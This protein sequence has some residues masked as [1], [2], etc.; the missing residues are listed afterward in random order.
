[1]SDMEHLDLTS[2]LGWHLSRIA[3]R[4]MVS[5]VREVHK[6]AFLSLA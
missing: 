4:D 5:D 1:M 6:V 2:A 3:A